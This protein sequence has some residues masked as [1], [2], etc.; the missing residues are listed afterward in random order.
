MVEPL[1]K[2]LPKITNE[3]PRNQETNAGRLVVNQCLTSV[4]WAT[5]ASIQMDTSQGRTD[6]SVFLRSSSLERKGGQPTTAPVTARKDLCLKPTQAS[7]NGGSPSLKSFLESCKYGPGLQSYS[8]SLLAWAS[9]RFSIW[10]VEVIMPVLGDAMRMKGECS[11]STQYCKPTEN[12]D[13]VTICLQVKKRKFITDW[14]F[15]CLKQGLAVLSRLASNS[16]V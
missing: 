11:L 14:G 5:R 4:L 8:C 12:G 7:S 16:W 1:P 2:N 13:C 10:K 9:L 3:Q 15:V 6:K